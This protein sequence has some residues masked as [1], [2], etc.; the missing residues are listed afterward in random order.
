MAQASQSAISHREGNMDANENSA[1]RL[2]PDT[3]QFRMASM[4]STDSERQFGS[5]RSQFGRDISNGYGFERGLSGSSGFH[6]RISSEFDYGYGRRGS[7]SSQFSGGSIGLPSASEVS[8]GRSM[9]ESSKFPRFHSDNSFYR[10]SSIDSLNAQEQHTVESLEM[11]RQAA[12]HYL[13]PAPRGSGTP[14][15]SSSKSFDPYPARGYE[16]SQAVTVTGKRYREE[17]IPESKFNPSGVFVS[18]T[19]DPGPAAD[20]GLHSSS[21]IQQ[22]EGAWSDV[23][24]DRTIRHP[25]YD[26]PSPLYREYI[27]QNGS[28]ASDP[29]EVRLI[30]SKKASTALSEY[31][32]PADGLSVTLEKH[33]R[34]YDEPEYY[35]DQDGKIKTAKPFIKACYLQH[36]PPGS[37]NNKSQLIVKIQRKGPVNDSGKSLPLTKCHGNFRFR[38]RFRIHK[39]D[40]QVLSDPIEI[41]SKQTRKKN[42]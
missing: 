38:F 19:S 34:Q 1:K 33:M 41:R 28:L 20:A 7:M 11:L 29:V 32:N 37:R 22:D 42:P 36:A 18:A 30:L 9:S 26:F 4:S 2:N 31:E 17:P 25:H 8:F 15:F 23:T 27:A 10:T 6:S 16:D 40:E 5:P 13:Q 35:D 24:M 14:Q 21:E 3:P 12:G 39:T